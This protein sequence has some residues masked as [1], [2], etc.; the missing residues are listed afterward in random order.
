MYEIIYSNHL[1]KK[2]KLLFVKLFKQTTS[3]IV[4]N[5][6]IIF[7]NE[8]KRKETTINLFISNWLIAHLSFK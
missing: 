4:A 2:E 6:Y 8:M 5:F 1:H 7:E 3:Y